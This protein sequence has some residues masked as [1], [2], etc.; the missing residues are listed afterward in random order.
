MIQIVLFLRKFEL[1]KKLHYDTQD[2]GIIINHF[3]LSF[4]CMFKTILYA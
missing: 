4:I 2:I 3:T 1:Q